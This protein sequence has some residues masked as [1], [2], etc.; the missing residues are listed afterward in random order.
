MTSSRFPIGVA[1]TRSGTG[2]PLSVERLERDEA[3]ADEPGV[4]P[5]LGL[6][7]LERRVRRRQRLPPRG[8]ERGLADELLAARPDVMVAMAPQP[9]RAAR[10]ATS[11]VP[12][13]MVAVADPVSIG[14]VPSLT[15]P[16]G[17][18]T[19]VTTLPRRVAFP[20]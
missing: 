1:Q 7:D 17:N 20:R 19:G 18:L 9:V 16:G 13:V 3:C 11:T 15:R 5:Q 14:L 8:C 10:D 4:V 12:I 6:D 2:S